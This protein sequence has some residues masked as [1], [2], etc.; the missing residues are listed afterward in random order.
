MVCE[1]IV[2]RKERTLIADETYTLLE[3]LFYSIDSERTNVIDINLFKDSMPGVSEFKRKQF[4]EMMKFLDI[5]L[6]RKVSFEDYLKIM[7]LRAM[8][9]GI[10][11][12]KQ[13]MKLR[14]LLGLTKKLLNDSLKD[15]INLLK[16]VIDP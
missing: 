7:V 2:T 8:R 16:M 5:D 9:R 13:D 12:D 6:D 10:K 3:N 14:K 15:V 11:W 4:D 1:S